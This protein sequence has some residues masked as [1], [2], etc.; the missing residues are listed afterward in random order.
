MALVLLSWVSL[1][2]MSF[3]LSVSNIHFMLRVIMLNIILLIVVAPIFYRDCKLHVIACTCFIN[4][5]YCN[6]KNFTTLWP[7]YHSNVMNQSMHRQLRK[8]DRLMTHTACLVSLV[9]NVS[10]WHKNAPGRGSVSKI[11]KLEQYTF[12]YISVNLW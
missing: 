8:I 1:C 11:T 9:S 12:L 3:M 4:N 7:H 2:W 10:G 6:C 5:I